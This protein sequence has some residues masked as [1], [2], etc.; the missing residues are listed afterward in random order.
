MKLSSDSLKLLRFAFP[1]LPASGRLI[2]ILLLFASLIS[3]AQTGSHTPAAYTCGTCE[4]QPSTLGKGITP[5]SGSWLPTKGHIRGLVVFIQTGSDKNTDAQWP[6]GSMPFWANEYAE[7]L[8]QYFH[9]M[10]FGQLDVRLDVHQSLMI[11]GKTEEQYV[12]WNKNFGDAIREIVDSLNSVVDF[13]EYDL[14][15]SENKAYRVE[16][17][18]DGKI[19]LIICIFRSIANTNFLPFSGVSD[20]GFAGYHFLDSTLSRW[21][22]GGT[23]FYND[24]GA[25]G[26]TITRSPGYRLVVGAEHA[27]NVTIHELGH[28]FFGEGHPAELY[29][30]LGVMGNAGNGYAMNSFERHLAGYISY[31]E[32]TPGIDTTIQLKDYVTT[33]DALLIP[34]PALDRGYFSLEY[35]QNVSEWDTAPA[36]GLYIFRIYDSWGHNQKKVQLISAEGAFEWALDSASNTIYPL[37]PSALTGYNRFQRIPLNG[38]NYWAPGWWGDARSAFTMQRPNFSV[39]KN[40]T[41]D[42]IFGRDTIRTNLHIN[43]LEMNENAATVRISYR[44]PVIL[45]V[46]QTEQRMSTLSPP[47]PHPLP[48]GENGIVTF[49]TRESGRIRISIFDLLGR[50]VR[51][52]VDSYISSGTHQR[53]FQ[54]AGL[55]PGTYRLLLIGPD[56][57]HTQPLLIV[58]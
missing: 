3:Y 39:M 43:L 23:G 54:T 37:R 11:T 6:L 22:Y 48:S 36:Q 32:S 2:P 8:G 17:G 25:S 51:L 10:S 24:A 29:G 46:E 7:R 56:G 34:I 19:D 31:R 47:Y 13:A 42:F 57:N 28:K 9:D 15:N 5:H 45:S 58:R 18:P 50:E 41:P 14:W 49:S 1:I 21:V 55:R 38:K 20:L 4:E 26:L 53:N 33:G 16:P 12:Y 35:R 27:F 52:L 30:G 44:E 40:P